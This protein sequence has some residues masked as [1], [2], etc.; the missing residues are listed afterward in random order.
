DGYTKIA[1]ELLEAIYKTKLTNYEYRVFMMIIRKTYGFNKKSDWIAQKQ[2]VEKTGIC[3]SHISRTIK[4]LLKKNMI[5]REG[6]KIGI[7]KDY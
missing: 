6:K 4:N 7:Q 1:N 5:T 3:K 2:I